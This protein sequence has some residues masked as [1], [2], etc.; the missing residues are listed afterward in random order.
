MMI[1]TCRLI[2]PS[3]SPRRLD[4][5]LD[6]L[7]IAVESL[8]ADGRQAVFRLRAS[9]GER[10]RALDVAGLLELARMRAQIAIADIEQRLQLIEGELRVH[11]EGAHDAEAHALV[12]QAVELRVLAAAA[13]VGNPG[14][15]RLARLG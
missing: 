12:H 14:G 15:R 11:R 5:R 6:V 7:E 1:A 8:T 10:L 13:A 2:S 4:D 3:R 9:P